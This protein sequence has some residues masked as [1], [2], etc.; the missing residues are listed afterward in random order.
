MSD[1]RFDSMDDEQLIVLI[2]D[3]GRGETVDYIMNKYKDLVRKKAASMYI[4]GADRDDLIQ[5]GMIG[6]FKAVRDYDAGRDASFSTFADLCISRQM[7]SAIKSLSRKKHMPLNSYISI[8]A[9]REDSDQGSDVSL[10]EILESDSNLIPEQYVLDQE[11]L[12]ILEENIDKDLSELERQVLD[13]YITGMSIKKIAGVL[14]RDEK[15]TD[16]AMQRV[17]AKLKKYLK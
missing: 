12:K 14:G 10:E 15:S 16:N 7:Y 6:L 2:H 5:E 3:G 17:R 8:Y 11:N 4:L 13:L 1:L 9:S